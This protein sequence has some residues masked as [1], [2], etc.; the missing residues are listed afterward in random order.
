MPR[1]KKLAQLLKT[2]PVRYKSLQHHRQL[3]DGLAHRVFAPMLEG[4]EALRQYV[5]SS[6][7][8][9]SRYGDSILDLGSDE[10][11]AA[12]EDLEPLQTGDH[13][14]DAARSDEGPFEK[15]LL[16]KLELGE[17]HL[18]AIIGD[19]GCG[20]SLVVEYLL[21]RPIADA[22]HCDDICGAGGTRIA[23]RFDFINDRP[24]SE[25][26]RDGTRRGR[27]RVELMDEICERIRASLED[28]TNLSEEDELIDFWDW[29][30][31]RLR[32][33]FYDSSVFVRLRNRLR[34]LQK[35]RGVDLQ[36]IEAR[37]VVMTE[38]VDNVE[39]RFQYCARLWHY[40][41]ETKHNGKFL[42]QLLVF[43]NVDALDSSVQ[44][45]LLSVLLSLAET[46][47][48]T[49][50]LLL[51][52][53]SLARRHKNTRVMDVVNHSGANP[54]E[55]V[56]DRLNRFAASPESFYKEA[57][58]IPPAEYERIVEFASRLY[59]AMR[60][61]PSHPVRKLAESLS[62]FDVRNALI[63]AQEIIKI[64]PEV[65]DD[66][67]VSADRIARELLRGG[68]PFYSLEGQPFVDNLFRTIDEAGWQRPLI[69][70]RI[71]KLVASSP[72]AR[73]MLD[74]I[75]QQ[76]TNF[77]YTDDGEICAAL[78]D[79]LDPRRQLL[80]SNGQDFY[81][82]SELAEN[83][84]DIVMVTEMGKGYSEHLYTNLDYIQEVMYDVVV[85]NEHLGV[86]ML[87]QTVQDRFRLVAGFLR[88]LF[89]ID[90]QET[91]TYLRLS[92]VVEYRN[93]FADGLLTHGMARNAADSVRAITTAIELDRAED[94]KTT[95][96][97]FESLKKEMD[98]IRKLFTDLEQDAERLNDRLKV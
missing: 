25:L 80:R 21:R 92:N 14:D 24:L 6:E 56:L 32:G 78:N 30:F 46:A 54:T 43:D 89:Y 22:N 88:F 18:I 77:G 23:V 50:I 31:S 70:L 97:D 69:K 27:I 33:A 74:D 86:P 39:L 8:D 3:V 98:D 82:V 65:R 41:L 95:A 20:K 36:D 62:G 26:V 38:V 29:E 44:S 79:L 45:A 58:R 9:R 84:N 15:S 4:E 55:V 12:T 94:S 87:D 48:S 68:G 5:L 76:M 96:D 93:K 1:R 35:D 17:K 85:D 40:A 28:S 91:A 61:T 10:D 71:L 34:K 90:R 63:F 57:E 81:A 60:R 19:I 11:P 52:P 53:E 59:E 64:D 16:G 83:G 51:R 75:L 37:R 7:D 73:T 2:R 42:C 13:P 49:V 47:R 72:R 66:I 67:S